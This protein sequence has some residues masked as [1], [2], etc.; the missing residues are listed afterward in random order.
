MIDEDLFELLPETDKADK[1]TQ[2]GIAGIFL[3]VPFFFMDLSKAE[4]IEVNALIKR[5]NH[6]VEIADNKDCNLHRTQI[7]DFEKTDY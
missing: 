2:L 7:P 1:N 3:V 5:H 4:Q 6:L